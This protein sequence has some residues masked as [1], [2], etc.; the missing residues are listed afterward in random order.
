MGRTAADPAVDHTALAV[1]NG[2]KGGQALAEWDTPDNANYDRVRDEVLAPDGLTEAQVQAVWLK[3]ALL[4]EP[5]RPALPAPGADAFE[6]ERALGDVLRSLRVRYPNLRLV[7]VSSRIFSYAPAGT[8]NSPEPYAYETGFGAKWAIEA[9]ARQRAGGP[10]D[11]EAGDL[12]GAVAPWVAWGPYLWAPGDRPRSDGLRWTRDLLQGDGVH[13]SEG[14]EAVVAGLLMDFFKGSPLTR[15]WFLAAPT[16]NEGGT[17]EAVVP[18][19]VRIEGT[20]TR[21]ASVVRLALVEGADVS[22][23]VYDALG[24]RMAVLHDGLL[25]AGTHALR[26]DATGLPPGVYV[27]FATSAMGVATQRLTV[28]R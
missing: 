21:G 24:R 17:G 18:L 3:A 11:A 10:V 4:R 12:S 7:F 8:T 13:P 26:L 9:Q 22:V 20:P 23:V 2:A 15:P 28:V 5:S 16:G 14:G 25:G 6:T 19:T 1:A 27:V